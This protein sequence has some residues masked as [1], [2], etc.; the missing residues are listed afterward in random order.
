MNL[1]C[2]YMCGYYLHE[3]FQTL[4]LITFCRFFGRAIDISRSL[5][6]TS[7]NDGR[8]AGSA[9]QHSSINFFHSESQRFGIGGLSVLFTIPPSKQN[10]KSQSKFKTEPLRHGKR[11]WTLVSFFFTNEECVRRLKNTRKKLLQKK[12]QSLDT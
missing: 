6:V 4:L 11:Q 10:N 1:L 7:V 5:F 3:D 12:F 9:D 2:L 8:D